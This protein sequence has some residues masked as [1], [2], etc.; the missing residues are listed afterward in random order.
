MPTP[1]RLARSVL[2]VPADRPDRFEKAWGCGA[3]AVLLDLEDAIATDRKEEARAN[4]A[5]WLTPQRAALVRINAS[6]SPWHERDLELLR[7]P[8][9]LG[10]VI[11]KAEVLQGSLLRACGKLGTAIIPL[12]ETAQGFQN[13]AGLAR[14]PGVLRL[15]FGHIDFQVDLAISGDDDAL[16]FFRSQ[17]VLVSRLAALAAP[18]DGITLD[19][20][21]S[22]RVQ[23]DA[24]RAKRCGFGGKLCIHPSQIDAVNR[25]FS[26]SPEELSWARSVL[27]VLG[28]AQGSVALDGKMIDRPVIL[29]AQR[30]V[31]AAALWNSDESTGG[32]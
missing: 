20:N 9:L 27:G 31:A 8:G 22:Q 18:L 32:V 23:L 24:Q 13:A 30:I 4:V 26:P 5:A 17:L 28:P 3:D 19:V 6:D 25:A 16:L 2:F 15:A 10:V 1:V 29:K 7:L 14:T 12:I 21:N 11:P